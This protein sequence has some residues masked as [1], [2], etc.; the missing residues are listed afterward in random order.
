MLSR[1]ESVDPAQVGPFRLVARLGTGGMGQVYLGR[2]AGGRLAAVKVIHAGLTGDP[3]FRARFAREIETAGRVAARWTAGVIAADPLGPR[4]W[5]ATEYVAGP[6]L[7]DAVARAGPLPEATARTLATRLSEALAALHAVDVV[8]RDLKPSNVLLAADGP[9]L[10]DF[11]IAHAVDATKITHTGQVMGTPAYM[12]PEQAVGEDAGPPSDVFSLASVL[13]FAASGN[14]PFGHTANPVA[15]L[16]R[17][18]DTEPDLSALAPAL[19][20]LLAPCLAKDPADRPTARSLA[21][22]LASANPP[23]IWLPPRTA[24]LVEQ[25]RQLVAGIDTWVPAGHSMPHTSVGPPPLPPLRRRWLPWLITAGALLAVGVVVAALLLPSG[26]GAAPT[27]AGTTGVAAA[28]TTPPAAAKQ[29][30]TLKVGNLPVKVVA[31]PDGKHVYVTTFDGISVIDTATGTVPATIALPGNPEAVAVSPDSRRMYVPTLDGFVTVL[32]TTSNSVITTVPVGE[33][34]DGT[35]ITP[36]GRTVYVL[37]AGSISVID[38]ATDAVTATIPSSQDPTVIF[39]TPDSRSIWVHE[40]DAKTISIIDTATNTV[41]TTLQNVRGAGVDGIAAAFT[42]DGG[43]VYLTGGLD[44]RAISVFDVQRRVKLGEIR[45]VDG[46][47]DDIAM[48]PNGRH[49]FVASGGSSQPAKIRVFDTTTHF[50][51]ADVP[52]ETAPRGIGISTDGRTLYVTSSDTDS[53][54]VVDASPYA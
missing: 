13:C 32:D 39:A 30:A 29:V 38:T 50:A 17:I 54:L 25:T 22:W 48:A 43:R 28:P 34:P 9:R 20:A 41:A 53:V 19:R 21:A 4:P 49:V 11:G 51:V 7:D 23:A 15:V 27:P 24:T 36:D 44:T 26:R 18:T 8:H 6:S 10:I 46:L 16:I 37:N 35:A 45:D 2:D 5:L 14:P 33:R 31:A 52:L 47:V 1:L 40:R 3:A 12:S 42:P